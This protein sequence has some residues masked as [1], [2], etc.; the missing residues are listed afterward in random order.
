M[1]RRRAK[2]FNVVNLELFQNGSNEH[3]GKV[4]NISK[5]G[6]LVTSNHEFAPGENHSFYIPFTQTINGEVKFKFNG[7]IIWCKPDPM[8]SSTFSIGMEFSDIPEI[9]TVF[10]QQMVKIYGEK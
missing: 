4:I 9:Q 1:E 10:I 3:I 2:R 6:I 7:D 5:G 8:S